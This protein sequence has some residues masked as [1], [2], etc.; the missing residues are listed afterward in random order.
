MALTVLTVGPKV[1]SATPIP[2][3]TTGIMFGTNSASLV[4]VTTNNP[5]ISFAG[6]STCQ[7]GSTGYDITPPGA[8]GDPIFQSAGDPNGQIKDIG[9]AFPITAFKTADL[10]IGGGPAIFDLVNIVTPTGY[11]A[12]TFTTAAG[13]CSTGTFILS[14]NANSVGIQLTVNEFGYLGSI[15][16]GATPYEGIFTSQVIGSLA[17]YGCVSSGAQ[18]CTATIANILLFEATSG[19]TNAAGLGTVGQSGTIR[20]SWSVQESPTGA[21][22]PEPTTFVLIGGGLLGLGIAKRRKSVA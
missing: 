10:T 7:A 13:S 8:I 16:S 3:A 6:A 9:T 5:C 15:A 2:Y 1:S 17:P 12:C 14:Q 19:Q 20:S 22:V 4:A 11:A 21:P 18:T